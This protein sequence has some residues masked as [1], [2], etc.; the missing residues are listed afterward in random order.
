MEKSTPW[1]TPSGKPLKPFIDLIESINEKY[2]S[3]I[4]Y[5]R[6]EEGYWDYGGMDGEGISSIPAIYDVETSA[7]PQYYQSGVGDYADA[8]LILEAEEKA[9]T[10]FSGYASISG[11]YADGIE[12]VYAPI[13]VDYSWYV[14]YLKRVPDYAAGRRKSG[15]TQDV[16]VGL[17]YELSMATHNFYA[18]PSTFYV[19]LNYLD[20]DD[21]YVGNR[22]PENHPASPEYNLIRIFNDDGYTL[23]DLQF[24][25]KIYNN[26]YYNAS[27]SP[28][29]NTINVLLIGSIT[30]P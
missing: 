17:T 12:E 2:P 9:T 27:S 7:S 6:W 29:V 11:V 5:V 10:S 13:K 15:V 8:K 18:T 1:F 23:S 20:R 19:N 30:P 28:S 3:N 26:I 21:F 14:S 4:G 16:G 25:D 22:L 24:K